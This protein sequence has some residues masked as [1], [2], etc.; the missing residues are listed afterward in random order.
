[1]AAATL[2]LSGKCE[3]T[4]SNSDSPA[5]QTQQSLRN[6]IV[7][8]YMAAFFVSNC[9]HTTSG[10]GLVCQ[11][12]PSIFVTA[13]NSAKILVDDVSVQL[14]SREAGPAFLM[15]GHQC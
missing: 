11:V 6:A 10:S 4:V 15:C 9:C 3:C 2:A 1:M 7:L 12:L 5:S 8:G 13:Q 14:I